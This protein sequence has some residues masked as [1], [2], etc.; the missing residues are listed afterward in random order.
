MNTPFYQVALDRIRYA[1]VWESYQNVYTALDIRTEDHVLVITSAGCNVLNT[2]LAKPKK[3]TAVDINPVQNRLLW[4]KTHVI[5]QHPY[6]VYRGMLGLDGPDAVRKAAAMILTTLPEKECAFWQSFFAVHPGGVLSSGR[7]EKYLHHF[8]DTLPPAFQAALITL[9]ECNTLEAQV[10][11]FKAQLDV[12]G[13]YKPF[14]AYFNNQNL[15][16]GRDLKLY[17]YAQK[18]GGEV[19]YERL[20]TFIQHH[21]IQNNFHFLFFFFGLHRLRDE[22]LP[23]CYREENYEAL[24]SSLDRLRIVTAEVVAYLLSEEGQSINKAGLSNIFEYISHAEFKQSIQAIA[25]GKGSIRFVFWNLLNNQGGE[26]FFEA[27]RADELSDALIGQE[28]CFY[29]DSI[30]VF[31]MP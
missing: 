26:N 18:S 27:W 15:S 16:R 11:F 3:V 31:C 10:S 23:P 17:Q 5:Q 14:M 19:F 28:T 4:L 7:L 8:Y 21:P 29:F 12:P 2:L 30:R 25:S 13:F 6:T 24:R 1:V 9:T 22:I 20:K